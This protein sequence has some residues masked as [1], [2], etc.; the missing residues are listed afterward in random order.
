MERNDTGTPKPFGGN[1]RP[2]VLSAVT[3]SDKD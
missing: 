2:T 1:L 3:S